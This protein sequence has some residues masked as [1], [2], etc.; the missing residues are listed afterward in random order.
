A[1]VAANIGGG[2]EVYKGISSLGIHMFRTLIDSVSVNVVENENN[3]SL[4]VDEAWLE[5]VIIRIVDDIISNI[6]DTELDSPLNSISITSSSTNEFD[7]DINPN[8]FTSPNNSV[9]ITSSTLGGVLR[10]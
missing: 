4:A 6:P 3:I 8:T 2:A 5:E 9:T 10:I 1:W 7:I